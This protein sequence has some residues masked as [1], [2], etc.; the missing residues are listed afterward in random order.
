M[1]RGVEEISEGDLR[2]L[3]KWF[4]SRTSERRGLLKRYN[5]GRQKTEALAARKQV[6]VLYFVL[7]CMCF[8]FCVC[9]DT[10][11]NSTNRDFY[12][13]SMYFCIVLYIL[14]SISVFMLCALLTVNISYVGLTCSF[15]FFRFVPSACFFS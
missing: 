3:A 9:F 8:V 5:A 6:T 2:E 13:V 1:P 11:E 12:S 10:T 7:L 15:S 4:R 14:R